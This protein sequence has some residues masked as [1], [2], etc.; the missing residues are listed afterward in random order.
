MI[1][2]DRMSPH[3]GSALWTNQV[4]TKLATT[5]ASFKYVHK[6]EH[7]PPAVLQYVQPVRAT[8]PL[9][10]QDSEEEVEG[11]GE[12]DAGQSGPDEGVGEGTCNNQRSAT[13]KPIG[14]RAAVC[15]WW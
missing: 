14:A 10:V 6:E 3:A 4:T 1:G 15:V 8:G 12:E 9:S 13:P 7:Q 11:D 5:F 2:L